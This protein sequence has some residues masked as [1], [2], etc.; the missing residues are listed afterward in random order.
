MY[1]KV[2]KITKD[3]KVG[4]LQSASIFGGLTS[5]SPI[6]DN[7]A[8]A[9]N[10]ADPQFANDLQKDINALRLP[11]KSF[12]AMSGVSADTA[13]IVEIKMTFTETSCVEAY[14]PPSDT[15]VTKLKM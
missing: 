1:M 15:P 12:S 8:E 13:H 5:A 7:P 4:Y 14:T 2:I 11:N 6:V 3:G 9:K 10:Y